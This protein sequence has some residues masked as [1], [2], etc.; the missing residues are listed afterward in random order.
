MSTILRMSTTTPSI[1]NLLCDFKGRDHFGV[2]S[3]MGNEAVKFDEM[4]E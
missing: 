3:F 1:Q 2:D 4:E